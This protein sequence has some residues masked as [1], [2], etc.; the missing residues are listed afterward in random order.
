MTRVSERR[1]LTPV[2]RIMKEP[3]ES[4]DDFEETLRKITPADLRRSMQETL[5]EMHIEAIIGV[6]TPM[7]FPAGVLEHIKAYETVHSL[8]R[9][10]LIPL[11]MEATKD[12]FEEVIDMMHRF[13]EDPYSFQWPIQDPLLCVAISFMRE[14]VHRW[15]R[16]VTEEY[17]DGNEDDDARRL[18]ENAYLIPPEMKELDDID[19]LVS[20][21]TSSYAAMSNLIAGLEQTERSKDQKKVLLRAKIRLTKSEKD[22]AK[23]NKEI[24]RLSDDSD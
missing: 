18:V 5:Q 6:P 9:E 10:R 1:H 4:E 15:A 3:D 21:F 14:V 24:A 8:D 20:I 19:A 7:W 23:L 2:L 11:A 17:G 16:K 12:R 22:F 13:R